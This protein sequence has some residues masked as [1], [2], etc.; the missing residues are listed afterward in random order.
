MRGE[1]FLLPIA[2]LSGSFRLMTKENHKLA[3][4]L[5]PSVYSEHGPG[6]H[7]MDTCRNLMFPIELAYEFLKCV[8]TP[9]YLKYIKYLIKITNKLK[10]ET[11]VFLHF[12]LSV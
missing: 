11:F 6:F 3:P 1:N 8:A 10:Y 12:F 9:I 2:K 7:C 4:S 5:L